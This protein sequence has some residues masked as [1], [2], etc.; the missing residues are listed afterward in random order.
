M[1]ARIPI[2][3]Y[4]D[5]FSLQPGETIEFKVSSTSTDPYSAKLVRV[6]SGDPNPESP[7]I[8][9]EE[10]AADFANSY[11]SRYQNF[12]LGSYMTVASAR[13]LNGLG[14]FTVGATICPTMPDKAD[15][16]VVSRFNAET[17]VGIA[18]VIGPN[19]AAALAG[20]GTGVVVRAETSKAMAERRW[21]YVW[22]SYDDDNGVLKTGQ[23][24][25]GSR[26]DADDSGDSEQL[27]CDR[28]E[29]SAD[30]PFLVAA[31]GCKSPSGNFNGKIE[32]PFIA[33][34]ALKD[35]D[36]LSVAAGENNSCLI[37]AWDFSQNMGGR[38]MMDV[39]PNGLTGIL[40]NL[41]TRAVTGSAWDGSC[42]AWTQNPAHYAAIHFHDD[43]L[44]DCEWETDFSFTAP[45][46]MKSAVYAVRLETSDG[47]KDMI[48]F[49]LTA[50]KNRPQSRICVLIPS[51]TYTVYA[52]IAR[53]NTNQ[54]FYERARAWGASPYTTDDHPQFGLSTY[55]YH[56]DGSGIAYSSR[57][58][59]IITMRSNITSYPEVRGS[60]CRHLPADTHLFHW[61]EKMGHEF[62]VITDDELHVWGKD[63][64][65]GY[66]LVIT[67]S[68]PEYHTPGSLDA[69]QDYVDEGGR[70][71]YLGG[72]G[73]YW[74]V[75]VSDG[76][77]DAVE[78]RRGEGGIRAWAADPGEYY[79]AF[80]GTYGGLWRRNGRA[81]QM[82][83]GVGFSSQGDH[84]GSRYRRTAASYDPN[85]AWIF[86]GIEGDLIGDFGFSG[87]GAAGF[88]LDRADMRLG[89][90][91][92]AVVLATSENHGDSFVLV[93]ED[94]LT[95]H[96]T[97]T[98]EPVDNLIRADIVYFD[99]PNGGAV[100]SVGSI[101]FCGSLPWN[102]CD[103]NVSTMTNNVVR[104]FLGN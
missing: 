58:R 102:D 32:R 95:H 47:E 61:L 3:G 80:D 41:P 10:V 96:D 56:S 35:A 38:E 63:A 9:E 103:N 53:G 15:Q 39:G 67:C 45:D 85:V 17:G 60:G 14:S 16:G 24:P 57:R 68:H 20:D 40:V 91:L 34:G 1:N 87:G 79:N 66:Q 88:E 23:R 92:N 98:H 69:L 50:P 81:P 55:N 46:D 75:A 84:D 59:P 37:A 6:I 83:A 64:V 31:L 49:F 43:D 65:N 51:Y 25:L 104:R 71:L 13:P 21:Y 62:D 18:L 36:A 52:N 26:I 89:T 33:S 90:P 5:R 48:P 72:N 12:S 11:P 73:F 27:S 44:Y 8:I 22:A 94:I 7:G 2:V 78:I 77:P 76:W 19:G 30:L 29:I 70:L 82:L 54:Q 99:T 97:W 100:F 93:P 4:A 28:P 101:T 86:E 74:K 42:F